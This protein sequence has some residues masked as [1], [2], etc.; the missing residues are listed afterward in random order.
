MRSSMLNTVWQTLYADDTVISLCD[1]NV[2]VVDISLLCMTGSNR[3][4]EMFV[5]PN[6][7]KCAEEAKVNIMSQTFPRRSVSYHC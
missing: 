4:L 6:E 2:D 1:S 3:I 7:R 5:K